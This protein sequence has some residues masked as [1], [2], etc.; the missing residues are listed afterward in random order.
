MSNQASS[1]SP[2]F[3]HPT[4]QSAPY[5]KAL[6]ELFQTIFVGIT[7]LPGPL[8]RP[9]WQE[10]PL[11]QP[12]RGTNWLG[13][14]VTTHPITQFP[15][16]IQSAGPDGQ[17]I[18]TENVHEDIGVLCSFYGPNAGQNANTLRLGLFIAQNRDMIKSV[19]LNFVDVGRQVRIPDLVNMAWIN[20][21]DLPT[22]FRRK[23]S[24]TYN[25]KNLLSAN[26]TF[27]TDGP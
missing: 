10:T 23:V 1:T 26:P 12:P 16:I 5:D 25:V 24:N 15:E 17:G 9:S 14:A 7:G 11:P 20:R 19:G 4:G 13:F 18:A 22:N 2:G 8:V 3:L 6:E 21:V 27:E